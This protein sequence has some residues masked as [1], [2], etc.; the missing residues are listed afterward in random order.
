MKFSLGL[1]TAA[2]L[3]LTSTT[4]QEVQAQPAAGG[5]RVIDIGGDAGVGW[6]EGVCYPPVTGVTAGDVLTFE[7]AG[8]DVYQLLSREEFDACDFSQGMLVA[9]VGASPFQYTVTEEDVA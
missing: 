4:T 9:G 1:W 3:L 2:L 8:H 7:F 5:G 6:T